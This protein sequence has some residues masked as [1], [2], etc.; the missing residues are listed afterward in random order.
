MLQKEP[1]GGWADPPQAEKPNIYDAFL[2]VID[3]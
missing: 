2:W 1:S 3:P